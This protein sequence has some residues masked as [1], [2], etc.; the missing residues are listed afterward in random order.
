MVREKK[1]FSVLD[2]FTLMCLQDFQGEVLRRAVLQTKKRGSAEHY[3]LWIMNL[4]ELLVKI[5]G[6]N[7]ITQGVFGLKSLFARQNLR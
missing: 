7:E 2:V 5:I 1:S 6:E 3:D 4:L